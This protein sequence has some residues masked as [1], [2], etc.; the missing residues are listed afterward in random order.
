MAAPPVTI[1][2]DPWTTPD[3][4]RECCIGLDPAYD[5]TAAIGF[6][7]EI[8]YRLSGRQF[9]GICERTIQP[10]M[11][12]NCGCDLDEFWRFSP[13]D[14]WWRFQGF[15]ATFG[16]VFPAFPVPTG[17]G[18]FFNIGCCSNGCELPCLDLPSTVNEVI[19]IVIDGEVLDPSAY[20]IEAFR[21]I[22]R[23]DGLEWP[24]FNNYLGD[25]VINVNE[26]QQ[27]TVDATGGQWEIEVTTQT[28]IPAELVDHTFAA[29]VDATATAAEV[30][31]AL[32]A[33][34]NMGDGS[35]TVSG[36]PGDAGGNFPYVIEFNVVELTSAPSVVI[37]DV[38]LAGGAATVTPLQTQ[39]GVR[40]PLG[41]WHVTYEYGKP[42]PDGGSYVAAI[43]AC[44]IALNRCGAEGCILPQRL[45]NITREGVEMAFAD[46][47]EFIDHGQVGIYEVDLWLNS[48]NPKKLQRRSRVYRADRPSGVTGPNK[49]FT[50]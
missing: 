33:L 24:C 1:P 47:L 4:V 6:A 48:V 10:C 29:V 20:K 11:G 27:A 8:L 37:S 17:R 22:C 45:K 44:Q 28:G 13:S 46:P 25:S 18:G 35:V 9:P 23:V 32:E 3:E 38:S 12:N 21:K 41:A 15:S 39:A 16:G 30:E 7:S 2:C 50:G 43:F 14:W 49:T 19:E 5:L 36:G 26:I 34:P 40:S 42:V 31:A